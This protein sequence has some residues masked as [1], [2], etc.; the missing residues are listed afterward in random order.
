MQRIRFFALS[1][2]KD[3]I[4]HFLNSAGAGGGTICP[5]LGNGAGLP[6]GGKGFT[7][8]GK[9][10]ETTP[11]ESKRP[12]SLRRAVRYDVDQSFGRKKR[13]LVF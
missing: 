5:E 8:S 3:A 13:T 6:I 4:H 11:I 7:S 1:A 10:E 2:I 9:K 12:D